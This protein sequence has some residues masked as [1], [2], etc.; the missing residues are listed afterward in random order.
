MPELVYQT[1]KSQFKSANK[2]FL[3]STHWEDFKVLLEYI[4]AG[5]FIKE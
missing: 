1:Y 5:N 3:A 4:D 2:L